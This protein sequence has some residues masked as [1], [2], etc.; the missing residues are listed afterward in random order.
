MMEWVVKLVCLLLL[1]S[2]IQA[3]RERLES[4]VLDAKQAYHKGIIEFVGIQLE[5]EL[6]LPGVKAEEQGR[7]RKNYPIRPLN[8]HWKTLVN[9]EQNPRRLYQFKR[10]ANRYNLT[11][12]RLIKAEKLEQA[13]RYR[14]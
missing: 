13:R 4:P 11:I 7:I 12:N 3:Q 14:Y 8:Q 9:S 10:Y 1:S 5:Q 2:T 6:L